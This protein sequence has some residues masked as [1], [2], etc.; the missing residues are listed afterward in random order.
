M[1]IE[2]LRHGNFASL[3]TAVDDWT[4]MIK[5]LVAMEKSA[6]D[7]L[8]VKA[9]RANWAGVNATVSREFINRTAGEFAD[10]VTQATSIRNILRDTRSELISC[11]DELNRAIDRGWDKHLS[12]A[13]VKG[14]GFSVYVNVHPEPVGSKEA[15]VP[16]RDEL[17]RI[18]VKATES[19]STAAEVLKALANHA[20]YGFSDAS[21]K[22]RDSAADAV[23]AAKDMAKIVKKDPETALPR[24]WQT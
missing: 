15:M 6:R 13:G 24:T 8:M 9:N 21:Y 19:D 14:G 17:Q 20:E 12:V 23:Q 18:L 4:G 22:D 7:D 10:A 11:R 2:A 16:L 1:D 3:D 5:H